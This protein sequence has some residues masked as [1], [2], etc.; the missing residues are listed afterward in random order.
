MSLDPLSAWVGC[1]AIITSALVGH[2][3]GH[4]PVDASVQSRAPLS[5]EPAPPTLEC[6]CQCEVAG[7]RFEPSAAVLFSLL[8]GVALMGCVCGVAAGSFCPCAAVR[9]RVE[10]PTPREG[11]GQ[12]FYPSLTQ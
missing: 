6:R 10:R 1:M 5:P 2:F 11:R 7:P 12:I 3:A 4:F 9:H 8:V